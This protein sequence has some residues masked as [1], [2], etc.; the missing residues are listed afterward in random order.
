M[1]RMRPILLG[2]L[3]AALLTKGADA[4]QAEPP[5]W[6]PGAQVRP[7]V[8]E[9]GANP[10]AHAPQLSANFYLQGCQKYIQQESDISSAYNRGRCDGTLLGLGYF[11]KE[12]PPDRSSCPPQGATTRQVIRV[13]VAYIER[14][15]QRMHEDFRNLAVE[16]M[17]EAWPCR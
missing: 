5:S 4:Q 12:L 15:P 9:S 10:A 6:L 2:A 14:R 7:A 3:V 8:P 11:I 1:T 17:H 13:V 16:A